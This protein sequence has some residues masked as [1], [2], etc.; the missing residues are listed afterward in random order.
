M[1]KT[2]KKAASKKVAAKG[3]SPMAMP[4]KGAKKMMPAKKSK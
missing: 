1:A 2:T 4:A 3:K